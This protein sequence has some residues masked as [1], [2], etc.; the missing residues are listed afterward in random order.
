M[1]VLEW[2]LS[3]SIIVLG[4]I[5]CVLYI[6][7]ICAEQNVKTSRTTYIAINLS[8]VKINEIT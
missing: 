2:S 1:N 7:R 6:P 4:H 8:L 3:F 5:S